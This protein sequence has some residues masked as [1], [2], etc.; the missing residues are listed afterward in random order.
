[1]PDDPLPDLAW[2]TQ[3]VRKGG[4]EDRPGVVI[5]TVA[6]ALILIAH[7]EHLVGLMAY[8]KFTETSLIMR[9]P[10]L[11]GPGETPLPGPYPRAW[12]HEDI[13]AVLS[14]MQRLWNTEFTARTVESAMA[15]NA[16][17]HVFHPVKEWLDARKWDGTPR[18]FQWLI[19]AFGTEKSEYV[20]AVGAKTLIAAVRR[21]RHPGCKFDTMLIL[22]GPQ[23]IK[24]STALQS[25]FSPEWFSDATVPD[26]GSKDAAM[27]LHGAWCLEFAEIAQLMRSEVETIK[28]FLS[29]AVDRYRPPYSKNTVE[30]PRQGIL[31]GTTNEQGFLRDASGNRRF[32][33]VECVMA[34]LKWIEKNREQLWAEACHYEAQGETIWLDDAIIEAQAMLAQAERVATDPWDDKVSDHIEGKEDDGVKVADI[35]KDCLYIDTP[36]QDLRSARRVASILRRLGWE[37]GRRM[38]DGVRSKVWLPVCPP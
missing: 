6:N 4:K 26:L 18:L 37:K 10:P 22:E 7:D 28:G 12:Q 23:G 21:V 2:M 9:A 5:P 19:S 3:L 24:K 1:M 17:T 20:K 8:N 29:R 36:F 15:Y 38:T 14:Y 16:L 35:L 25:L 11:A 32:W 27:C 34:N 33:P 31:I 13:T 30:K